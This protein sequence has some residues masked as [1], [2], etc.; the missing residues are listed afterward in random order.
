MMKVKNMT[1]QVL[2]RNLR[3]NRRPTSSN[4]IS[5]LANNGYAPQGIYNFNL[6]FPV[7]KIL[8]LE[9]LGKGDAT[10]KPMIDLFKGQA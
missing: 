2:E 4:I 1:S 3:S 9:N 6:L 10:A 8:D 5:P 7:E